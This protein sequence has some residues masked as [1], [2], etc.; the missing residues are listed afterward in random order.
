MV[1]YVKLWH[2]VPIYAVPLQANSSLKLV[3][4]YKLNMPLKKAAPVEA[5]LKQKTVYMM[6]KSS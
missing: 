3:L 1:Y 5:F 2:I 6:P 4:F